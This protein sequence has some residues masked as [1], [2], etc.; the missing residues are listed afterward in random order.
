MCL[1]SLDLFS[2]TYLY[3]FKHKKLEMSKGKYEVIFVDQW[4]EDDGFKS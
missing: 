2:L 4:L 1:R 3:Y